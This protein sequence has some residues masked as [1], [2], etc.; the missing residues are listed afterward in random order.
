M[1]IIIMNAIIMKILQIQT[2]KQEQY[3]RIAW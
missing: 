1:D 3:N 2:Y